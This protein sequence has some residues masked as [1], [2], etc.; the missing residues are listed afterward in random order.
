MLER[1]GL[2]LGTK[3]VVRPFTDY[4]GTVKEFGGKATEHSRFNYQT[5]KEEVTYYCAVR[6]EWDD[7]QT[8]WVSSVD[9]CPIP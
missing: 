2:K 3:V 6:V 4:E 8:N 9:C 5:Q 7:G 1:N